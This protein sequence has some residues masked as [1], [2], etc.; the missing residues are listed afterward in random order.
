MLKKI[1]SPESCA[2]CRVCCVFD[3]EDIWEIPLLSE[4]LLSYVLK[5]VDSDIKYEKQGDEYR[6]LMS[7][8]EGEELSYCPVLTETGCA[9]GDKKPFD[10]RVWPFRVNRISDNICGITVSPVC[11]CVSELSLKK[12]S[13]FLFDS[14]EGE[15]LADVMFSY[16]KEHPDNI[17]PYI[18]NYP[19]LAVR[20]M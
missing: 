3:K 10:C 19:I 8:G 18:E 4:E 12:L 5:N 14:S 13:E 15:S 16:V 17:K 7:F 11:G 2:K 9:L 1:L 20:K 6:L